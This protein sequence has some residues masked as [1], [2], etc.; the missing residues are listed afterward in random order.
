MLYLSNPYSHST[1]YWYITYVYKY[2]VVGTLSQHY[3]Y[4]V[5]MYMVGVM[6][7]L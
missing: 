6:G 4:Y 7:G 5:H 1:F 3:K 2:C